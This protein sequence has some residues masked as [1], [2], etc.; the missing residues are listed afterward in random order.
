MRLARSFSVVALLT[1]VSSFLGY[2]RDAAMAAR[3]GA[4]MVTD[5]YFA[6]FFVPNTL[7][8]ILLSNSVAIVFLP[9]FVEAFHKDR[10]NAWHV[11]SSLF[12]LSFLFLSAVVLLTSVTAKFWM[13]I[14]YSGFPEPTMEL[15]VTL[16]QILMPMLVFIGLTTIVTAVLN[17][18]DHFTIPAFAPVLS[19]IIVIVAILLSY[20]WWDIVGVSVA[21]T[22][23]ALF[24]LL[25]QLPIL[26]RFN[27]Q[28]SLSLKIRD[29]M[30]VR[31]FRL[32]I[33]LI[34]Y[35]VIA[36]A[37][38]AVERNIASSLVVGTVSAVSYAA[39]LFR[40]PIAI[41]AGSIS[42]VIYPRLSLEASSQ[43]NDQF[44]SSMSRA[45][46]ATTMFL[47]PLSCWLLINSESLV[48]A[49]FGFGRFSAGDVHLT[50]T[51]LAGYAFGMTANGITRILQRAFYAVQDTVT[52]VAVEVV[53]FVIYTALVILLVKMVGIVG[54]GIARSVYFLVVALLSFWLLRKHPEVSIRGQKYRLMFGQY[55]GASAG[56]S[57][58]WLG[59]AW[60][61]GAY[62]VLTGRL[63]ELTYLGLSAV[64][65]TVIFV[66]IAYAFKVDEIEVLVHHS[67]LYYSNWRVRHRSSA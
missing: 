5:A 37:S 47:L 42:T 18:F 29:P 32:A 64:V 44:A 3:F 16:T 34:I 4:S 41:F 27:S 62:P 56:A 21:V 22:L 1:L 35:F 28:Y 55:F 25:I 31:V 23:S 50:A 52:P 7:S 33:P 8:L 17:S 57:I 2:V 11:A 24:Q 14:L 43:T 38:Q 49:L 6:A 66:V 59:L 40:V 39:N 51:I 9:I 12:N 53:S 58:V 65:G 48:N 10:R 54:L 30:I 26:R 20:Y 63:A 15:A 67:K 45:I 19:N 60:L 36:Y 61:H 13:P 46:G